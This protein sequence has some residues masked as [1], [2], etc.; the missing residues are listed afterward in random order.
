MRESE[1]RITGFGPGEEKEVGYAERTAHGCVVA[2]LVRA[3][4]LRA[5]F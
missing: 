3:P 5:G 4:F 1:V 2:E